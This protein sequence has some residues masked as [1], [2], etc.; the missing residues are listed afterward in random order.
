M[1]YISYGGDGGT[2]GDGSLAAYDL[3]HRRIVWEVH[4]HRGVDSFAISR[5][6]LRIYLPDGERSPDGV[7]SV[8]DA[9]D[10]A[11]IGTISAGTGPHNTVVGLSGRHGYLGGRNFPY[12][13]VA[14]T[15]TDRVI[16][17]IGPLYSG[18]RPFTINGRET[19]AFTT[20]TAFLGF[21]V[22]SVATGR[23]LYAARVHEI[24]P[25]PG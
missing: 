14:D 13:E 15:A 24:L 17:R 12:L 22:S 18:V 6:G 3:I 11:V 4:Y 25:A 16:R 7:W 9:R 8:V 19:L 2:D 10:G 21:Q 20:A 5:D 23:V 1:L